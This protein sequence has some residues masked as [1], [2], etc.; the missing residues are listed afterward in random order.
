[1]NQEPLKEGPEVG[2]VQGEGRGRERYW[3]LRCGNEE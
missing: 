1:M 2:E 3:S